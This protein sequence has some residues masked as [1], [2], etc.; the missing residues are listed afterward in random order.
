MK[1]SGVRRVSKPGKALAANTKARTYFPIA[2]RLEGLAVLIVGGDEEAAKRAQTLANG[3]AQVHVV[4]RKVTEPIADLA[5][6]GCISHSPRDFRP[7][8]LDGT[9]V[10]FVCD[11]SLADMVLDEAHKRGV[12]VNVV[13]VP[14]QC[15][16][17]VPATFSRDGLQLAI[18]TSGKSAALARRIREQLEGEFGRS[19]GDLTRM[20]GELRP[21]VRGKIPEA[22]MRREFWL[23][24]ID[25]DL[26][27][28]VREGLGVETLREWI[29]AEADLE[30]SSPTG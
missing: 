10:V 19:F 5:D 24:V 20:L 7:S 9:R 8:D 3:G 14:E 27:D 4:S 6:S 26:L 23:R 22:A 15:D 2:L 13:D 28:R 18:H 17:I 25:G 11:V 12:L 30:A 1:E 16:F 29:L 21:C